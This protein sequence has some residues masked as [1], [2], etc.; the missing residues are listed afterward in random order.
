MSLTFASACQDSALPHV[1][2]LYDCV[3]FCLQDVPLN[4]E[5]QPDLQSGVIACCSAIHQSV[6]RHSVRYFEELR[7]HNYVSIALTCCV[8]VCVHW[9]VQLCKISIMSNLCAAAI[10]LPCQ[11]RIAW[12]SNLGNSIVVKT[13]K[14]PLQSLGVM[15]MQV[16]PASYLELLT[17]F[18]KLLAEKR[19]DI[20]VSRQRLEAGL[21]KLL[22][23]AA[24]VEVMQVTCS[25]CVL[26]SPD[27]VGSCKLLQ[28]QV[29]SNVESELYVT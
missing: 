27:F 17:T 15:A 2:S 13:S 28:A 11:T 9:S 4:N 24:Q 10:M 20:G 6:E 12:P 16:T 29:S 25:T 21:S 5:K 19:K 1:V 14:A 23:T 8:L 3:S 22:T 26:R 7:R 18:I